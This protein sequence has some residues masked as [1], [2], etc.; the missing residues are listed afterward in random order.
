MKSQWWRFKSAF[1]VFG[2]CWVIIAGQTIAGIGE[3]AWSTVF[4]ADDQ[5]ITIDY[6][7]PQDTSWSR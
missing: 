6:N 1:W 5:T 3:W 4:P 2:F 7:T